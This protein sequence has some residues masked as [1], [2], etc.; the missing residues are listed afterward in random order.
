MTKKELKKHQENTKINNKE[1]IQKY[2][3]DNKHI[4]NQKFDLC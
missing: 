3:Q 4:I 2:Y 1:Q